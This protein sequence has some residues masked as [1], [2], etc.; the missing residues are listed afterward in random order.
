M[1]YSDEVLS[2]VSDCDNVMRVVHLPVQSGSNEVLNRMR[3]G[4]TVEQYLET[5]GRV[6]AICPD[7]NIVT[8]IMVGFCG[9]TDSDFRQSVELIEQ[10]R[11]AK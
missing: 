1:T 2:A 3:R 8:D 10:V 5:I 4:Y 11:P 9:E 7:M 6:R